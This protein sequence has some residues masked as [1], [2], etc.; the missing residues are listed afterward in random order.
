MTTFQIHRSHALGLESARQLA[1]HWADAAEKKHQMTC[2]VSELEDRHRVTF[3]R[4]GVHGDLVA[5]VDEFVLTVSLGFLVA[6][7]GPRIREEI[8]KNLDATIAEAGAKARP[9]SE[10]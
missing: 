1:R 8:E 2:T 9:V 4:P 7:F 10:G 3:E 6:A 5:K